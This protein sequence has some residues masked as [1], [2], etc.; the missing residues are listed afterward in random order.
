L[1]GDKRRQDLI[2]IDLNE[3]D[4]LDENESMLSEVSH[5]SV[6]IDDALAH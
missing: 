5:V 6:R 1:K 4:E 2:D 3:I